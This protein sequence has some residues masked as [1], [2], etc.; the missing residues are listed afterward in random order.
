MQVRASRTL[1]RTSGALRSLETFPTKA[2]ADQELAH[3]VSRMA[4]G[5][6]RDPRLGEQPLGE[7]FR[8]WIATR[9]DLAPSTRALYSRLLER[10]IDAE[11]PVAGGSRPRAVRLGAQSLASLTPAAVREWA[12]GANTVTARHR[13]ARRTSA[14]SD[15]TSDSVRVV[16]Q[17]RFTRGA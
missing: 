10:W 15:R 17:Q 16:G 6:W 13:P 3:E 14:R 11:V 2:E 1:C 5:V 4:R 7:W 8:G 9:G 12:D